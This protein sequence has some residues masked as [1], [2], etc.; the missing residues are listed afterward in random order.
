MYFGQD[1]SE[2]MDL[3]VGNF[4]EMHFA[5]GNLEEFDLSLGSWA[6]SYLVMDSFADTFEDFA[7]IGLEKV[8]FEDIA[9]FLGLA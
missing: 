1:N 7:G 6:E 9:A 2:G 3:F 8:L 5:F 4:G